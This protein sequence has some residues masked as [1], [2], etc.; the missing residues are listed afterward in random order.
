MGCIEQGK[1]LCNDRSDSRRM[2]ELPSSDEERDPCFDAY[3]LNSTHGL[4]ATHHMAHLH[5]SSPR[6]VAGG[7]AYLRA[8]SIY[9]CITRIP[10]QYSLLHHSLNRDSQTQ[11]TKEVTNHMLTACGSIY[12][13]PSLLNPSAPLVL[14]TLNSPIRLSSQP[15]RPLSSWMGLTESWGR[16]ISHHKGCD[17]DEREEA[18]E[19]C[20]R[21]ELVSIH[22]DVA[23]ARGV[24]KVAPSLSLVR[25]KGVKRHSGGE[26]G[27]ETTMC[28]SQRSDR[29]HTSSIL[30]VP[31]DSGSAVMH[32]RGATRCDWTKG[33]VEEKEHGESIIG[34]RFS[35]STAQS[36]SLNLVR[37]LS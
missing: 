24:V 18:I 29:A 10:H 8:Y 31:R 35:T 36:E 30:D 15:P 25:C 9:G 6:S 28:D 33:E 17:T 12:V 27:E 16:S 5:P 34:G 2:H 20:N 7:L 21:D 3:E 13:P 19:H 32:Y 22:L 37:T 23:C 11:K 4:L 1:L 14:T 26:R